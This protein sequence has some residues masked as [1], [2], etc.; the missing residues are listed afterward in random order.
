MFI[1]AG[2]DA[3]SQ[4]APAFAALA[5]RPQARSPRRGTVSLATRG[6]L[7]FERATLSRTTPDWSHPGLSGYL[8][9]LSIN[10]TLPPIRAQ[11]LCYWLS[12]H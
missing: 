7:S 11:S 8:L 12:T 1:L 10:K 3:E 9:S 5:R 2:N 6:S 4:K